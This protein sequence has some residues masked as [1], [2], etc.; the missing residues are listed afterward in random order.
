MWPGLGVPTALSPSFLSDQRGTLYLSC[1]LL[2]PGR[3]SRA[4]SLPIFWLSAQKQ[5]GPKDTCLSEVTT[6]GSNVT[7]TWEQSGHL[8]GRCGHKDSCL[9]N[10]RMCW[11]LL[12]GGKTPPDAPFLSPPPDTQ[13]LLAR[14]AGR[15]LLTRC[16]PCW[17]KQMGRPP[18]AAMPRGPAC[19]EVRGSGS[20]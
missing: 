9:T 7:L 20:P 13:L 14:G 8:P 1:V 5:T 18:H 15:S 2:L 10:R 6:Q 17:A 19:T 12:T 11:E 4:T 16:G 3:V